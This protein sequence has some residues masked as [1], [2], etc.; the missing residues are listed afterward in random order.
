MSE[1]L[2]ENNLRINLPKY[3]FT[4]TEIEWLDYKFSQSGFSPIELKTPAIL[5]L[6]AAKT[7]QQLRYFS[8]SVHYLGTIKPNLA[9]MSSTSTTSWKEFGIMNQKHI[10][11]TF[12]IK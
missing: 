6:A 9:I 12:K 5:D 3:H 10:S 8:G 7:L 11:N 1:K 2:D 4:K